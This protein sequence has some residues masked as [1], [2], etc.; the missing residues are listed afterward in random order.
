MTIGAAER[1]NIFDGRNFDAP[2]KLNFQGFT[3]PKLKSSPLKNGWLEDDP[4]PF[5]MA[6]YSGATCYFQ[7]GY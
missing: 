2:P 5:E 3:P 7:G 1:R 4:F 6:P